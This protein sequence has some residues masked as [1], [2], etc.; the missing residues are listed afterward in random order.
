MDGYSEK[1]R[2]E[3]TFLTHYKT[4][5][6]HFAKPTLGFA[7]LAEFYRKHLFDASSQN[8]KF[9]RLSALAPG[10]ATGNSIPASTEANLSHGRKEGQV[11]L[12]P[13]LWIQNSPLW[14]SPRIRSLDNTFRR[15][16]SSNAFASY[17][18]CP[19][20]VQR[21]E[22]P[23]L[24]FDF[25]KWQRDSCFLTLFPLEYMNNRVNHSDHAKWNYLLL[26]SINDTPRYNDILSIL[27]EYSNKNMNQK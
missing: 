20:S 16:T 22:N 25:P 27:F 8:E 21:E 17:I 18:E 19:L 10:Y 5:H 26:S 15:Y 24:P 2:G 13:L 12:A 4:R 7:T 1:I 23:G 9:V 11:R 3:M 6:C 14:S